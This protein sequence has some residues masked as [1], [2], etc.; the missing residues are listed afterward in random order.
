MKELFYTYKDRME[1]PIVT[2][3]LLKKGRQ[4]AR[5]IALCSKQDHRKDAL[6][7]TKAKGRAIKAVTRKEPDLPINRD[8]AIRTLFEVEAPPFKYKAEYPAKLTMYEQQ[9]FAAT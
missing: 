9:L 2:V 8:E 5:G 7:E 3:C 4:F 6:G 1:K